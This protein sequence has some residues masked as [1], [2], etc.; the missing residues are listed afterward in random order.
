MIIM[1]IFIAHNASEPKSRV[2]LFNG[3][4][5]SEEKCKP[6]TKEEKNSKE[7]EEENSKEEE[8]EN[9]KEEEEENSKEEEETEQ[10]RN[11]TEVEGDNEDCIQH[12]VENESV[13]HASIL[14]THSNAQH[15]DIGLP[16]AKRKKLD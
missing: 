4:I 2:Y 13:E 7:E 8:E 14:P 16:T 6:E 11:S 3:G 1:L 5:W 12:V 9:S 15:S 10:E